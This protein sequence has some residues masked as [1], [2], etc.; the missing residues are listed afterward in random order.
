MSANFHR[1][2]VKILG[3]IGYVAIVAQWLL[4]ADLWLPRFLNSGLGKLV[5]PQS[6]TELNVPHPAVSA[7]ASSGPDFVTIFLV[8]CLAVASIGLVIYMVTVRYTRAI[9]HTGSQITHAVAK[10]AL[11]TIAHKPLAEMPVRKRAVLSRRLLFWTK[12][13]L[14]LVPLA[15]LALVLSGGTREIV[16]LLALLVQTVL[17]TAAVLT[18]LV[19]SLLASHWHERLDDIS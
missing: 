9:S 11:R 19:Q 18:F 17:A 5:F 4:V 13:V 12:V 3:G 7:G 16:A 15:L 10:R 2:I 1:N 8:L 14:T 6:H